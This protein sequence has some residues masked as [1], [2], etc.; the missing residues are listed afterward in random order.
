MDDV[1]AVSPCAFPLSYSSIFMNS[2]PPP[3]IQGNIFVFS[4]SQIVYAAGN[5][6]YYKQYFEIGFKIYN[7]F[8]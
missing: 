4:E 7:N 3:Q 2:D 5:L 6:F 8:V 1:S